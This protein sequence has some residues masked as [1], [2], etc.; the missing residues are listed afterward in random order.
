MSGKLLGDF[1]EDLPEKSV[2]LH[3]IRFVH[4]GHPLYSVFGRPLPAP[5]SLES[6]PDNPFGPFPGDDQRVH[7]RLV[8]DAKTAPAESVKTLG[9]LPE[10]DIINP[11]LPGLLQWGFNTGVQ[12]D[13]PD[14]GVQ[15]QVLPIDISR[16]HFPS[17]R[18]TDIG[19]A[20]CSKVD[21]IRFPYLFNVLLPKS[22]ARSPITGRTDLQFGELHIQRNQVQGSPDDF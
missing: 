3:H 1:F 19:K 17:V 5:R 2:S 7:R 18:Q 22:C 14:I 6:G 12:F 13:R 9:V 4:A 16:L 10:N 15:V 20:H 11:L 8:A 21:R